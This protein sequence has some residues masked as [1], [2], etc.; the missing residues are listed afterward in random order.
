ML[1]TLF[2]Y[3]PREIDTLLGAFIVDLIINGT[4]Q[5]GGVRQPHR[6]GAV[7]WFEPAQLETAPTKY[8]E[9]KCLFIFNI[10][11]NSPVI[12]SS[13]Q[14]YGGARCPPTD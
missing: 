7:V 8:G 6:I 10:H 2:L 9:R 4:L 13:G 3:E 1:C 14:G 11:H 12:R 5:I